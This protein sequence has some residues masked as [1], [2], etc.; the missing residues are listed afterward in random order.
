PYGPD[1]DALGARGV[2]WGSW[3]RPGYGDSTRLPGR[4][5]AAVVADARFILDELGVERAYVAGWSGGGPHALACAA[6]MPDR[7]IATAL[8][9]GVAPYPAEG[10]D[11]LA[12]MGAENFE[13]FEAALDGPDALIGFKERNWPVFSRITGSEVAA[14]FGDL[15]DDVDRGSIR[16]EFADYLATCFRSGLR[17]G[18]WGWFDDDMAF[19][20]PWGFDVGAVPGRVHVWQGAHDRMVPFGHGEWLASHLP[21]AIP[22]L[23]PDEGHLTLIVDQFPRILDALLARPTASDSPG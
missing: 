14:A 5:V 18:Y 17:P 23:F 22:H 15:V 4:T 12:G 19:V 8:L 11:Y 3:S 6:L 20:K 21:G 9:A 7:V 16:A 1:L 10:L 2:R 13:E